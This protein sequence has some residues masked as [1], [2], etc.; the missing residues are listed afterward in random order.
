VVQTAELAQGGIV[1][2]VRTGAPPVDLVAFARSARG[3]VLVRCEDGVRSSGVAE[4]LCA[5]GVD[6]AWIPEGAP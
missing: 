5:L 2:D 4:R 1:L 6:A 3:P